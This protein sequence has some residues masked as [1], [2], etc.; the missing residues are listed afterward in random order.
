MQVEGLAEKINFAQ[1]GPEVGMGTNHAVCPCEDSDNAAR[2]DQFFK[3]GN[4]S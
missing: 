1:D 3:M 2:F 4:L